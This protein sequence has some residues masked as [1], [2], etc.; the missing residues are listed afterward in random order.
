[1]LTQACGAKIDK[2]KAGNY[3]TGFPVKDLATDQTWLTTQSRHYY[4]DEESLD[5][6][7]LHV[8]FRSLNDNTIEGLAHDTYPAF[9]VQFNPEGAPGANDTVYLFNQFIDL[10]TENTEINGGQQHA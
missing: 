5:G 8:T 7:D 1:M 6:T 10:M 4:V 9:S 2:L 3:G